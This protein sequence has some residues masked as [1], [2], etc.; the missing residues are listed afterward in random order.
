MTRRRPD[1]SFG[2]YGY[3]TEREE[4]YMQKRNRYG[5]QRYRGTFDMIDAVFG[6]VV[7]WIK[8]VFGRPKK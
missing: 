2:A 5:S 1:N 6:T 7:S 3:T 8:F 4:R